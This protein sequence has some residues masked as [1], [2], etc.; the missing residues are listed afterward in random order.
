MTKK[1]IYEKLLKGI[2]ELVEEAEEELR[3]IDTKNV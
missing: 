1:E 2:S 3:K